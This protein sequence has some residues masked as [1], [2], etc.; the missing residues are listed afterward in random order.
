MPDAS[1]SGELESPMPTPE[2]VPDVPPGAVPPSGL[3]PG[4]SACAS[5]SAVR[6]VESEF[7]ALTVVVVPDLDEDADSGDF[8]ATDFSDSSVARVTRGS[9]SAS[10]SLSSRSTSA[11]VRTRTGVSA[12][13][14]RTADTAARPTA[15]APAAIAAHAVIDSQLCLMHPVCPFARLI[16]P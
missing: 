16:P 4:R 10:G 7:D 8:V 5:E 9:S 3:V 11:A 6:P 12:T 15:A 14:S 13:T 1:G 2:T